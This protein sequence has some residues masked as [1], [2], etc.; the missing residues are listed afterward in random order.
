MSY[1]YRPSARIDIAGQSL[2]A[3]E[4]GLVSLAVSCGLGCHGRADIRLWYRSKFA[5]AQVGETCTI[6]L[7]PMGDETLV[8][9]GAVAARRQRDGAMELEVLDAG[10]PLSRARKTLTFE[11]SS[12]DDIVAQLAQEVGL[13]VQSDAGD[14]LP[15][16]YVSAARPIWDH[17]R[18]LA[19]LTGR[20]LHVDPEGRLLFLQ[21]SAGAQHEVRYGAELMAWDVA[22]TDAPAALTFAPHGGEA[23]GG[24]WH[25]IGADP[26]G[27]APGLAQVVGGF[28][29]Q[30]LADTATE[31]DATRVARAQVNGN[32]MVTGNAGLR[33]GDNLTVTG[34][35]G[36]DP[37]PMRIRTVRHMLNGEV[38]FVTHLAVE[39]GGDGGVL[40]A[41]GGLI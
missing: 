34:V 29:S 12:V 13:D 35:P 26:L 19:R 14:L 24:S 4:A 16:H 5:E 20:D 1:T 2:S 7:G 40:G 3:E 22:A 39:G 15:I 31:A 33:P 41:L 38:G 18:D 36:G 17:L 23:A 10:G 25:H 9:T 21:A 37:E 27:D 32:V 6:A 28:S 30:A 11:D 8:L